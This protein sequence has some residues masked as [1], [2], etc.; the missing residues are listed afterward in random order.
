MAI[1][2]EIKSEGKTKMQGILWLLAMGGGGWRGPVLLLRI[3]G[4]GVRLPS[5]APSIL[6]G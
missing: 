3:W 2:G 6:G 5:D 4:L 1:N